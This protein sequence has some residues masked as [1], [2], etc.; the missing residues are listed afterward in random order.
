MIVERMSHDGL[1]SERWIFDF[2]WT[3]KNEFAWFCREYVRKERKAKRAKTWN[4]VAYFG[5]YPAYS[6][7]EKTRLTE[8]PLDAALVAEVRRIA[9][10]APVLSRYEVS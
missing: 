6:G 1:T 5:D 4:V 10:E 8:A 7:V 3:P 9:A 2:Q